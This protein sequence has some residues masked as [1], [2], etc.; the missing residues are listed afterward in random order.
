[1]THSRRRSVMLTRSVA[2]LALAGLLVAGCAHD[3]PQRTATTLFTE[4]QL[5]SGVVDGQPLT[6]GDVDAVLRFDAAGG[7]HAVAACNGT[8]GTVTVEAATLTW[9]D[10]AATTAMYCSPSPADAIDTAFGSLTG[11]QVSWAVSADRLILTA[12]D[13]TTLTYRVRNPISA[14]KNLD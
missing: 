10:V 2:S 6:V 14:Q 13:G 4:W 8:F 9:A 7:W 1:M 11:Q 5:V 3:Q 12:P